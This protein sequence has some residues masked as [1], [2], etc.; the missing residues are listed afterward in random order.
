MT[1]KRAD[2]VKHGRF[3][4]SADAY[5]E[6]ARLQRSYAREMAERIE[7]GQPVIIIDA[8]AML[9][10]R[11]GQQKWRGRPPAGTRSGWAAEKEAIKAAA[12][13]MECDKPFD[14]GLVAYAL[15]KWADALRLRRP[16][17][18][19][20]PPKIDHANVALEFESNKRRREVSDFQLTGELAEKYQVDESTIR[21]ARI[22][23][24]D[25]AK[26]LFDRFPRK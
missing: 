21:D 17:R 20:R 8:V 10:D 24:G 12:A 1:R 2:V 19:G 13:C 3:L 15:R 9:R 6:V 26:R 23:C 11:A 14:T 22:A 18:R 7:R 5:A 16:A 25:A 4:Q